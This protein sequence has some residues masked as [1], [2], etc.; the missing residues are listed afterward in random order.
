MAGYRCPNYFSELQKHTAFN[1]LKYKRYSPYLKAK[2]FIVLRNAKVLKYA[3]T[4]ELHGNVNMRKSRSIQGVVGQPRQANLVV[5]AHDSGTLSSSKI[6]FPY[7]S[8]FLFP[9]RIRS[10]GVP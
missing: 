10:R 2:G 9:G 6:T 5:S 4:Q 8:Y 1:N 3:K 7:F